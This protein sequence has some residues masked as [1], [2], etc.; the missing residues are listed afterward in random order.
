MLNLLWCSGPPRSTP[1][2]TRGAKQSSQGSAG[3]SCRKGLPN[4]SP[5]DPDPIGNFRPQKLRARAALDPKQLRHSFL[6]PLPAPIIMTSYL[7]T[8]SYT[9]LDRGLI[10][11]PLLRLAIRKLCRQRLDEIKSTSLTEGLE[12]KWKYIAELGEVEEVGKGVNEANEQHYEVCLL[13]FCSL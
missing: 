9:L 8:Y 4:R 10:P 7:T 5:K 11:D 13:S 2:H 3:S 6:L 12:K 1:I